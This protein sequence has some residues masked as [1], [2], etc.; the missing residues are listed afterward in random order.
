[1]SDVIAA[2][3]QFVVESARFTVFSQGNSVRAVSSSRIV[4]ESLNLW[5]VGTIR[6]FMG[7]CR[8]CLTLSRAGSSAVGWMAWGVGVSVVVVFFLLLLA[9]AAGVVSDMVVVA[10]VTSSSSAW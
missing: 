6:W 10:R 3:T 5:P 2:S 1:M 9:G 8:V 4:V 7:R